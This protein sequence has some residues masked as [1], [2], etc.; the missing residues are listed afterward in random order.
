M[1]SRRRS[2]SILVLLPFFLLAVVTSSVGAGAPNEGDYNAQACGHG[3]AFVNAFSK[4]LAAGSYSTTQML[5][6]KEDDIWHRV[7]GKCNGAWQLVRG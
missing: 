2:L 7:S 1:T 3:P 5:L 4:E 6:A